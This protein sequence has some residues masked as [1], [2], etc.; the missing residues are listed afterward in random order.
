MVAGRPRSRATAQPSSATLSP[1]RTLRCTLERPPTPGGTQRSPVRY[2]QE[3]TPAGEKESPAARKKRQDRNRRAETNAIG[4]A[5]R[6]AAPQRQSLA[7]VEYKAAEAMLDG[8]R[9]GDALAKLASI[10]D[11]SSQHA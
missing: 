3:L 2:K 7:Q 11:I 9:H 10:A 6:A 4:K 8:E 5:S 1:N